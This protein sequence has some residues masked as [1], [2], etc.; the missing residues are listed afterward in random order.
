MT[1]VFFQDRGSLGTPLLER[2]TT[3]GGGVGVTQFGADDMIL[4]F[5]VAPF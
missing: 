5:F 2:C 1:V 3:G 4:S